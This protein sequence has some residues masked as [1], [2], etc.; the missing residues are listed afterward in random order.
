MSLSVPESWNDVL[1]E[2]TENGYHDPKGQCRKVF[3]EIYD[4]AKSSFGVQQLQ[5]IPFRTKEWSSVTVNLSFEDERQ[6]IRTDAFNAVWDWIAANAFLQPGI[7]SPVL[8]FQ[9]TSG[10]SV[11]CVRAMVGVRVDGSYIIAQQNRRQSDTIMVHCRWKGGQRKFEHSI[12]RIFNEKFD[13]FLLKKKN[14]VNIKSKAVP[15]RTTMNVSEMITAAHNAWKNEIPR[16][17]IC[18]KIRGG[19]EDRFLDFY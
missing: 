9:T 12:K 2:F 19:N 3:S 15:G 16:C 10:G 1:K 14:Y 13:A 4:D 7:N 11:G 17:T 8:V 18:G 5:M 6:L